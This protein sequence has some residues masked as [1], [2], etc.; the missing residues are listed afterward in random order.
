MNIMDENLHKNDLSKIA[1]WISAKCINQIETHIVK[2]P[3]SIFLKQIKEMESTYKEFPKD[4]KRTEK[5]FKLLESGKSIQPIYVEDGDKSLFVMEGRHRMV[6]FLWKGLE[7]ID[8]CFC[9]LK[10]A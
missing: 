2:L 5:I 6:A 3:I 10:T 7:E 1:G 9:K 4:K 8:V